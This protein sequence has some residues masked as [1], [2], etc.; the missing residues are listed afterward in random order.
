[1]NHQAALSKKTAMHKPFLPTAA[2]NY[3]NPATQPQSPPAALEPQR[4]APPPA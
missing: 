2:G 4:Q 1:M 3:S